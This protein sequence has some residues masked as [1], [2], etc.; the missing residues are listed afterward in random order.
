MADTDGN[1]FFWVRGERP[2]TQEYTVR[3]DITLTTS[4]DPIARMT[5][6]V[7]PA[8][9]YY[10]IPLTFPAEIPTDSAYTMLMRVLNSNGLPVSEEQKVRVRFPEDW[11]Q[12]V[13]VECQEPEEGAR[14]VPGARG[15]R[16]A[17]RRIDLHG[18]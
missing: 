4:G 17:A 15:D 7:Q 6:M 8:R 2:L 5:P 16:Y 3:D 10:D 13:P 12:Q 18:G 9:Y 11:Q 14:R 1:D